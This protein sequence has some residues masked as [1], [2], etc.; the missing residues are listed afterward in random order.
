[1]AKAWKP[2]GVDVK[3]LAPGVKNII[4]GG[5]RANESYKN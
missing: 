2:Y 1:M 3:L 4:A 5:K